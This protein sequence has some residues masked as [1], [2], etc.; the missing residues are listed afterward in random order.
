[1]LQI[2][3][4]LACG[5]HK[6]NRQTILPQAGVLELFKTLP[7]RKVRSLGGKFGC[8][9]MEQLGCKVMADLLQFTES[10]LQQQFDAKTG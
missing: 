4:K 5:L 6:P 7:I 9:V 3:G 2:L 1:V 8:V 10:Q